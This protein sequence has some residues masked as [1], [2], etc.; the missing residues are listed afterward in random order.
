MTFARIQRLTECWVLGAVSVKHSLAFQASHFPDFKIRMFWCA[1]G[2]GRPPCR[3]MS[4]YGK[5]S[6]GA[7]WLQLQAWRGGG[8]FIQLENGDSLSLYRES[9]MEVPFLFSEP[10]RVLRG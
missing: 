3:V 1:G 2:D 6:G 4:T 7:G 8:G 9:W 5:G 10:Q